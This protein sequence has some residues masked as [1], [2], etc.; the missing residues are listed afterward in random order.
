MK[1]QGKIPLL[2]VGSPQC[3]NDTVADSISKD[4]YRIIHAS[5]SFDAI[6]LF[7][8]NDVD[9]CVIDADVGEIDGFSLAKQMRTLCPDIPIIFLID[10]GRHSPMLR[11]L[12]FHIDDYVVK[13]L[14][15]KE[16]GL[17]VAMMAKRINNNNPNNI[18]NGDKIIYLGSFI[19]DTKNL[20]LIHEGREQPLTR[21]EAALLKVFYD[22]KNE[23]VPRK[24]VLKMI[25]GSS[26]Y[27]IGRSMDVFIAR[28][29]KYLKPDPDVNI[30]TVHG[31]GFR[32]VVLEPV[33]G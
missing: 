13:P 23:L 1:T 27:F 24:K 32:L 9:I 6:E 2:F 33:M 19:F 26:D 16:L 4:N 7:K 22:N 29:R 28:L 5:N 20:L 21:K 12:D 18:D 30:V 14:V 3:L 11:N 25:W 17:R 10:I 15:N 8:K 31:V